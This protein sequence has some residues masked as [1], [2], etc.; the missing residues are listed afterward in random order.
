MI[1]LWL[2]AN[3]ARSVMKEVFMNKFNVNK[4]T[5]IWA[6]NLSRL[7]VKT[8]LTQLLCISLLA[9]CLVNFA[10]SRAHAENPVVSHA[11]TLPSDVALEEGLT[12]EFT[13]S[14]VEKLIPW[15]KCTRENLRETLEL[16]E[17]TEVRPDRQVERLI[18]AFQSIVKSSSPQANELFLRYLMN[19]GLKLVKIDLFQSK[20]TA[21]GSS[22]M[23]HARRAEFLKN[24]GAKALT[25]LESELKWLGDLGDKENTKLDLSKRDRAKFGIEAFDIALHYTR[26]IINAKAQVKALYVAM[27]LLRED[28]FDK[29]KQEY[30]QAF[31]RET[32]NL[33]S[34]LE[35]VGNPDA[36]LADSDNE[37][38]QSTYR[39]LLATA[40]QVHKKN[41]EIYSGLQ[42]QHTAELDLIV[43]N[44]SKLSDVVKNDDGKT[45][46]NMSPIDAEAY[47]KNQGTRLP[48]IRELAEEARDQFNAKGIRETKHPDVSNWSREVRAEIA[49]SDKDGYK[50]IYKK[51]PDG[52]YAIDFYFNK[53]GDSR[54]VGE[55]V[56]F[57]FYSSS[58]FPGYPG[59]AYGLTN[60]G[61]VFFTLDRHD[62]T[63]NGAVRCVRSG[64]NLLI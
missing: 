34:V 62:R 49:D 12:V 51:T 30:T 6:F 32:L 48:T 63:D 47:C 39:K 20:L 50:A 17:K 59:S 38:C 43:Q 26:Q 10:G 54:P 40:L 11:P 56:K 27:L 57:Y 16:I 46:R 53:S 52:H 1:I 2:G 28:L 35:A 64:I 4:N 8:L 44:K 15:A 58:V 45:V 14:D 23:D 37:E 19:R 33:T 55:L 29:A 18:A 42:P 22:G 9:T 31:A 41:A 21:K 24:I 13:K 25:Y 60:D 5:S 36:W 3:A 7:K 61:D